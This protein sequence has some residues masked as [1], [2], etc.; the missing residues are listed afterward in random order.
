MP[1][2]PESAA[3]TIQAWFRGVRVRLSCSLKKEPVQRHLGW[4]Q[5]NSRT[6]SLHSA[7]LTLYDPYD[8]EQAN[9]Q[10]LQAKAKHVVVSEE[11]IDTSAVL[12]NSSFSN[13]SPGLDDSRYD[14]ANRSRLRLKPIGQKRQ[15]SKSPYDSVWSQ[16]VLSDFYQVKTKSDVVIKRSRS[17]I[18][19]RDESVRELQLKR[20]NSHKPKRRSNPKLVSRVPY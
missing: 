19:M 12:K 8:W 20:S 18:T 1:T 6:L 2:A 9:W 11:T 13:P 7:G 4:R 15:Q 14:D 5:L 17:R 3:L 16:R 10:R